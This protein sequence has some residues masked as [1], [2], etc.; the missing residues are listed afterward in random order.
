MN[1]AIVMLVFFALLILGVR[2]FVAM[3][4]TAA[5]GL[6]LLLGPDQ[7]LRDV[8]S[9]LWQSSAIYAFIAIPLFVFTGVLIEAT[10]LGED[11]LEFANAFVGRIPNALAVAVVGSSALF[12]SICGSSVA[13]SCRTSSEVRTSGV[14]RRLALCRTH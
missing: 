2:V 3:G 12:A 11:M 7:A 6:T 1:V 8:A 10:G 9:F 13:S 4:I 14:V 5:L